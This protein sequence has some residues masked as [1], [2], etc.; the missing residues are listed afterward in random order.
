MAPLAPTFGL[1]KV[2]FH[3]HWRI[4][5]IISFPMFAY[6]PYLAITLSSNSSKTSSKTSSFNKT[7]PHDFSDDSS[8]PPPQQRLSLIILIIIRHSW[9]SFWF[10]FFYVRVW[11]LISFTTDMNF[12]VGFG[13]YVLWKNKSSNLVAL[14]K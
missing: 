4:S 12:W 11:R 9:V 8:P 7:L 3:I 6:E 5:S 14:T 1:L 10:D 13:S 2:L